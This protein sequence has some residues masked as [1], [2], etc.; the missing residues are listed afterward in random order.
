MNK[1]EEEMWDKLS[2]T[3]QDRAMRDLLEMLD[4][5]SQKID[6][7]PRPRHVYVHMDGTVTYD[8]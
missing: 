2:T 4:A 8:E 1:S 6:E 5:T 7:N 3:R